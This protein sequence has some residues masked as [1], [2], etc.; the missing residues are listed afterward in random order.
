MTDHDIQ[1]CAFEDIFELAADARDDGIRAKDR[2]SGQ[3]FRV[4]EK[5]MICLW[6]PGNRSSTKRISHWW[7]H[8]DHRDGGVGQAL[9]ERA[10]HEAKESDCDTLDIYVYDEELVDE[11]G[12]EH[13]PESSQAMDDAM[14]YVLDFE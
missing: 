6:E 8:P 7:V 9:F 5:G 10:F 12:F 2:G 11:Y 3:W 4:S 13:R 1:A 14:Y